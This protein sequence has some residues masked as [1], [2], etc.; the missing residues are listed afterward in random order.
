MRCKM[1]LFAQ[2]YAA[3]TDF[4]NGGVDISA[5]AAAYWHHDERSVTIWIP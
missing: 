5:P 3:Q 2:L 1:G 4:R